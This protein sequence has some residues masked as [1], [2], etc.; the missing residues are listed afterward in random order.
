[1]LGNNADTFMTTPMRTTVVKGGNS[2]YGGYNTMPNPRK[3]GS[4][5]RVVQQV[6]G[7]SDDSTTADSSDVVN[8]LAQAAQQ[9][10]PKQA[11]NIQAV[12]QRITPTAPAKSN[13][14]LYVGL[15]IAALVGGFFLLRKRA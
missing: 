4:A 5:T 11:D 2:A 7:L 15:G 14:M 8:Q 1:M 10:I 6:C 12:A 9:C 13:T 3:G